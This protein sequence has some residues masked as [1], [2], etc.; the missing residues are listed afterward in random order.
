MKFA[1]LITNLSLMMLGVALLTGSP[2]ATKSVAPTVIAIS[3]INCLIY[4][5]TK[6]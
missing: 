5:Y 2:E 1:V 4:A 3:I 6:E